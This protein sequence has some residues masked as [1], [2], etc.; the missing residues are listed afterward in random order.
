MLNRVLHFMSMRGR[1]VSACKSD[2]PPHLGLP[3]DSAQQTLLWNV[4]LLQHRL[5]IS[6]QMH[7]HESKTAVGN[8]HLDRSTAIHN[9][10]SMHSSQGTDSTG[11][12]TR[13]AT[14]SNSG[15]VPDARLAY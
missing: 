15:K 14:E 3:L 12:T 8:S 13:G 9:S 4:L 5:H 7:A 2:V 1:R 10:N 11:S 6:H